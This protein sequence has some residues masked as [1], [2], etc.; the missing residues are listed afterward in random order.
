MSTT[1]YSNLSQITM[2][3]VTQIKCKHLLIC[4]SLEWINGLKSLIK[5]V[6]TIS[7]LN[8]RNL[9]FLDSKAALL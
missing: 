2:K 6:S 8:N 9:S 7:K 3:S 4:I 5:T 1:L